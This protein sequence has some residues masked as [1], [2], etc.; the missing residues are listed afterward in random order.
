MVLN[1]GKNCNVQPKTKD[2]ELRAPSLKESRVSSAQSS[3]KFQCALNNGMEIR[4][5]DSQ[6]VLAMNEERSV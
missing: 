5:G 4:L 1:P 2:K 6:V 3:V